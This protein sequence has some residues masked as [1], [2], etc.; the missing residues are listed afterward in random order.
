MRSSTLNAFAVRE[1]SREWGALA[2]GKLEEHLKELGAVWPT[3]LGLFAASS[4]VLLLAATG[5]RRRR[6]PTA[7]SGI[8]RRRGRLL[9]LLEGRMRCAS[10]DGRVGRQSGGTG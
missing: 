4:R 9:L 5:G 10:K 2:R 8:W 6:R 1:G 3:P 7:A